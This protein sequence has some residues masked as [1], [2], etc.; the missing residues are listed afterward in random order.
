MQASTKNKVDYII[1]NYPNYMSINPYFDHHKLKE[2]GQL[3]IS[4]GLYDCKY[5]TEINETALI[6]IVLYAKGEKK[7]KCRG[8]K[9]NV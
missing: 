6:N 8:K 3:L 9:Y 4:A 7:N 2:I 1:A 5:Y